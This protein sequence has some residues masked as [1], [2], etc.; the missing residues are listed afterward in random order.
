MVLGWRPEVRVS[1]FGRGGRWRLNTVRCKCAFK[2]TLHVKRKRRPAGL[3]EGGHRAHVLA[4]NAKRAGQQHSRDST[5][6]EIGDDAACL[7]LARRKQESQLG[8][9]KPYAT[10][11]AE[12]RWKKALREAEGPRSRAAL[13]RVVQQRGGRSLS[14]FGAAARSL[15]QCMPATR[16]DRPTTFTPSRFRTSCTTPRD[17]HPPCDGDAPVRC[18][19]TRP[20]HTR[21][22]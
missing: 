1:D 11:K 21:L 17:R 14:Q 3:G 9:K 5:K 4:H 10:I 8:S 22:S 16:A 19:F 2:N 18:T 15:P 12:R 6:S 13:L 7:S 20:V